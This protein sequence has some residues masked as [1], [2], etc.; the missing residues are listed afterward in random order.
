MGI[1]FYVYKDHPS[2]MLILYYYR[3]LSKVLNPVS[4]GAIGQEERGSQGILSFKVIFR[5]GRDVS[6]T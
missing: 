3:I 2:N 6:L 4:L 5:F 1:I